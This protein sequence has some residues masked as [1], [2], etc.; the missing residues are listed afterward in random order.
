[1]SG[2]LPIDRVRSAEQAPR[3]L[4]EHRQRYAE[5]Q[6]K[7]RDRSHAPDDVEQAS[8]QHEAEE[9]EHHA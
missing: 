1:M 2:K 7:L 3:I 9:E 6:A 5:D 4:D 8:T